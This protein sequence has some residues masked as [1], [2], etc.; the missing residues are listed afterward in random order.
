MKTDLQYLPPILIM[1][2]ALA[3]YTR[4]WLHARHERKA[5]VARLNLILKGR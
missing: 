4:Q 2:L 3:S 1:A 5:V